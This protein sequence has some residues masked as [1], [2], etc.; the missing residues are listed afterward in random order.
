MVISYFIFSSRPVMDLVTDMQ[1]CHRLKKGK[2]QTIVKSTSRKNCLKLLERKKIFKTWTIVP[3][4]Y[5]KE[6][7]S[8]SMEGVPETC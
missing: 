4:T 5:L 7:K 1:S 6:Q 8:L 2:T 3:W